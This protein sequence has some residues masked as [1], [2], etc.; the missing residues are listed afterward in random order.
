[1]ASYFSIK[2]TGIE[3]GAPVEKHDALDHD[4]V[5]SLLEFYGY[6]HTEHVPYGYTEI[7]TLYASTIVD[8]R[9]PI[10]NW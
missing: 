2:I 4:A 7:N 10:A 3:T 1:M 9:S 5:L 8:T 6:R